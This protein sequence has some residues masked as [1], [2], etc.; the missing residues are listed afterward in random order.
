MSNAPLFPGRDP[1]AGTD[2]LLDALLKHALRRPVP[3]TQEW[4]SVLRR[5]APGILKWVGAF[6]LSIAILIGVI[7]NHRSEQH[8]SPAM[9][10]QSA[11]QP[12]GTPSSPILTPQLQPAPTPAATPSGS[13]SR[14]KEYLANNPPTP[15]ATFVQHVPRATLVK[16]PGAPR[17]QLVGDLP[18]PVVGRQY[19]AT[20]PYD[21]LEVL[22]TFRGWLPS[23]DDLPSHPNAIGD[24]YLVGNVPFVWIFAPGA[25]HADWI[26]P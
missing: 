18:P 12:G 10:N 16:L 25:T 6:G 5:F 21:N 20:M 14:W 19:L 7:G 9:A 23:Q 17:A 2:P 22:A 4:P 26:D 11:P 13:A 8:N 3:V 15:R 1:H 24:M